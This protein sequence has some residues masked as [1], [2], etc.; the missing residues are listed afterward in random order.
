MPAFLHPKAISVFLHFVIV[1]N[2]TA[3]NRDVRSF[4][5][6]QVF[7]TVVHYHAM[8]DWSVSQAAVTTSRVQVQIAVWA[9]ESGD[10]DRT[11]AE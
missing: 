9:P 7:R 8:A 4:N 6:L 5:L 2:Q 1:W 11:I 10:W 3:L